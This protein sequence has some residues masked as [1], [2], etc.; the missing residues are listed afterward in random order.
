MR[1]AGWES[2]VAA[3]I[4]EQRRG[5]KDH[6]TLSPTA[7]PTEASTVRPLCVHCA[8]SAFPPPPL[9]IHCTCQ[10]RTLH[11]T[12]AATLDTVLGNWVLL[13]PQATRPATVRASCCPA[14]LSHLLPLQTPE[15]GSEAKPKSH[16]LALS[17]RE[18]GGSASDTFTC[19]GRRRALPSANSGDGAP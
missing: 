17:A 16:A 1:E 19:F 3:K 12:A 15:G 6:R 13:P 7:P 10:A 8:S 14:S 18:A 5:C 11:T 9:H 4:C 2:G